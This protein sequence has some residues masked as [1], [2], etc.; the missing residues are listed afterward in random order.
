MFKFPFSKKDENGN[1]KGDELE[2]IAARSDFDLSQQHQRFSGKPQHVFDEPNCAQ[3][4]R[5]LP[6]DEQDDLLSASPATRTGK[7]TITKSGVETEAAA[8]RATDDANALA[9]EILRSA[10]HRAERRCGSFDRS[11][12]SA[13]GL[14]SETV[15]T[16]DKG[17]S[18]Q[19]N[20][21]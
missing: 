8:K 2:G 14:S 13:N 15:K 4:R 18:G 3:R 16:D 11:R 9:K 20:L 21:R 6:K 19:R 17:K 7:I 12:S 1:V 5:K 10:R